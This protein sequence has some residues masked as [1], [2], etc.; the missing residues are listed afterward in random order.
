MGCSESRT[1]ERIK[2]NERKTMEFDESETDFNL[3]E[4]IKDEDIQCLTKIFESEIGVDYK[5]KSFFNR[6]ALHVAC[7]L[8]SAKVVE[9]L[10]KLGASSQIEDSYGITAIF[11]A[12]VKGHTKCVQ[13]IKSCASD[14]VDIESK[15]REKSGSLDNGKISSTRRF[16][17]Q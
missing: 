16:S 12:E 9:F 1:I 11:L 13:L 14:Y 7:V 10:L 4:A 17:L 5:I 6:T 2:Q 3:Y 8:G 15:I